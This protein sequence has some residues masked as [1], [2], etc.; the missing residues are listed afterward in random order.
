[1]TLK[2]NLDV[3]N[4]QVLPMSGWFPCLSQGMWLRLPQPHIKAMLKVQSRCCCWEV[5][6]IWSSNRY[7]KYLK[8]ANY[9][10]LRLRNAIANHHIQCSSR[11]WL[12]FSLVSI[13]FPCISE[14]LK[15]HS[16]FAR[17][18]YKPTRISRNKIHAHN[19]LPLPHLQVV[20]SSKNQS[21]HQIW[22]RYC[23]RDKVNRTY[24][25]PD[26]DVIIK[27]RECQ[28][29]E[30]GCFQ[31]LT[32]EAHIFNLNWWWLQTGS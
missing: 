24:Q 16:M 18:K 28:C 12:L 11:S 22:R 1:M 23:K 5:S 2:N 17:K 13:P 32:P 29:F 9:L 25:P 6:T 26:T 8:N 30:K 7:C 21:Q 14:N 31:T 15:P 19:Q 4:G 27:A 3:Q 20:Q 10:T